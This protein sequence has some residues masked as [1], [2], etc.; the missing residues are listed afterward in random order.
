MAFKTF[1][2]NSLTVGFCNKKDKDGFGVC[3]T[4]LLYIEVL[5]IMHQL[6]KQIYFNNYIVV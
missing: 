5:K 2:H 4:I 6:I 3:T 1:C